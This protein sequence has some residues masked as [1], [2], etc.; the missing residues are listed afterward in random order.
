MVLSSPRANIGF[1]K[2]AASIAPSALPAPAEKM[3]CQITRNFIDATVFCPLFKQLRN[4]F[5]S[6]N[7]QHAVSKQ[8]DHCSM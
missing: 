7:Q 6:C 8:G 1:S 3:K 2:L 4:A 5:T